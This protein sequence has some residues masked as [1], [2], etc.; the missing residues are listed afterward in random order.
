MNLF[1]K[2]GT[3]DAEVRRRTAIR[4]SWFV[5]VSSFRHSTSSLRRLTSAMVASLAFL[6]V[7]GCQKPQAPVAAPI[8]PPVEFSFR[9]SQIPTRGMV[10]GV[11]NTSS[12]E[13]LEGLV[14]RVHSP[15]EEGVRSHVIGSLLPQDTI[16][17]GW[18][19][20]DGWVLKPG[21]E[22]TVSCD[23]YTGEANTTVPEL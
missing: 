9:E 5:V 13:T 8:A 10:V 16:T 22:M 3:I 21:D 11:Q 20:L 19:E 12:D 4:A 18:M 6:V 23:Q 15:G 1:T 7:P 14:V 17:V 2:L